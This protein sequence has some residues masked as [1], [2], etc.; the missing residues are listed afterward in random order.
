ML[1]FLLIADCVVQGHVIN[2][3]QI[4]DQQARKVMQIHQTSVSKK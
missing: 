3:L 1:Y 2:S 4:K